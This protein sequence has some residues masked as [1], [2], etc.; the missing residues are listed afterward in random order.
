MENKSYPIFTAKH[1]IT[2]SILRCQ[3]PKYH[4]HQ[5]VFD[6]WAKQMKKNKSQVFFS[7]T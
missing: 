5:T 3:L 6:T 4:W 7:T 2:S 1:R